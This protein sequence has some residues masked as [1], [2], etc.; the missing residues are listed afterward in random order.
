MGFGK[1]A[2]GES[3][4]ENRDWTVKRD[5]DLSRPIHTST[6]LIYPELYNEVYH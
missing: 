5:D 1:S 6:A 3:V 2:F 4:S